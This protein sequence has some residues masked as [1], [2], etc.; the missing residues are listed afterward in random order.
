MFCDFFL[1]TFGGRVGVG[2]VIEV[3]VLGVGEVDGVG[4]FSVTV[5]L[6]LFW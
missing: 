6:C 5:F 3:E 1:C 2:W 4:S